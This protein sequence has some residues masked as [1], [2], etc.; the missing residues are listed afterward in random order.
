VRKP[1]G[2][3]RIYPAK[4]QQRSGLTPSTYLHERM[5]MRF[6]TPATSTSGM[7]VADT[8]RTEEMK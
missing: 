8:R 4:Q 1:E 2:N 3:V 5:Q 7:G 6:S